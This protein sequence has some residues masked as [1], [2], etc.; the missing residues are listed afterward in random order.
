VDFKLVLG[1][2]HVQVTT[3]DNHFHHVVVRQES[4]QED[5]I[6]G[7]HQGGGKDSS[8]ELERNSRWKSRVS[9]S[10]TVLVECLLVCLLLSS[11]YA[12]TS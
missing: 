12:R 5:N 11:L 3:L 7:S 8:I 6:F 9:S 10:S 4:V 2:H 1:D